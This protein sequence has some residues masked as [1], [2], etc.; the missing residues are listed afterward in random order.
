MAAVLGIDAAWTEKQPSGVALARKRRSGWH[1]LSV[2]PSYQ[3]FIGAP[4]D[5]ERKKIRPTGSLP[6]VSALLAKASELCDA[7]PDLVAIDMPMAFGPIVGR[8]VSDNLVSKAFGSKWCSTHSPSEK[9]PGKISDNVKAEFDRKGYPLLTS[10]ID[11]RGLI[12]VYPHPALVH[13]SHASKRLPYKVARMRGYWPKASKEERRSRIF[14]QWARIL[15]LLEGEILG[16]K[17]ALP[18]IAQGAPTWELKSYE[19][20]LDAVVCAYVAICTLEGRA[21]AFG[22]HESAIWIPNSS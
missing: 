15:E 12:E 14:K 13:L 9:R 8:R 2:Q 3:A 19:D 7:P 22:D 1:L 18:L 21:T 11:S 16:T 20:M 5:V 17:K 10:S 6:D 4:I